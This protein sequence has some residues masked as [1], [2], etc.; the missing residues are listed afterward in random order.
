MDDFK[1]TFFED[2]IAWHRQNV[3]G[4]KST[5]RLSPKSQWKLVL[6]TSLGRHGK[7]EVPKSR[8]FGITPFG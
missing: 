7:V 3:D 4:Y 5:L 1:T 2:L 8:G 6:E